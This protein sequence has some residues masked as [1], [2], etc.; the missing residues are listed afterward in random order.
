M[1]PTEQ[2]HVFPQRLQHVLQVAP[3][4]G[5]VVRGPRIS[6]SPQARGLA[7]GSFRRRNGKVRSLCCCFCCATVMSSSVGPFRNASVFPFC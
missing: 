2:V 3:A 7:A 6:V 5:G 1:W 4:H